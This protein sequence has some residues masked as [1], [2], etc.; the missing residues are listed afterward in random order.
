MKVLISLFISLTPLFAKNIYFVQNSPD[1]QELEAKIISQIAKTFI[2]KPKIFISGAQEELIFYFS[3]NLTVEKDCNNANFIYIKKDS[4]F[5]I[6]NCE[7]ENK[8]I[9][10]D[11]KHIFRKNEYIFGAFYWFKS[12]PNVQISSKKAKSLD[13][14]IPADYLKFVD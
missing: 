14:K 8:I 4:D 6:N 7:H 10:T 3:G 9:F 2:D 1:I 11:N 12:R 5:D 13:I